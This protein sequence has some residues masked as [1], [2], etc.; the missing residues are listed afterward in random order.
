MVII[1]QNANWA[2][3]AFSSS[4]RQIDFEYGIMELK[5]W[6]INDFLGKPVALSSLE[7]RHQ[8]ESTDPALVWMWVF[9]GDSAGG[10]FGPSLLVSASW[11]GMLS[12]K[13]V[14]TDR[15]KM[16]VGGGGDEGEYLEHSSTKQVMR[17]RWE[18]RNQETAE[19]E[20]ETTWYVYKTSVSHIWAN[21][22]FGSRWSKQDFR[23]LCR[24]V[25]SR[26]YELIK[27]N[28]SI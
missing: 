8:T 16:L 19:N 14:T 3:E 27:R 17:C 21:T 1:H 7:V 9:L 4:M 10:H 6:R 13:I 15:W 2:T 5:M 11:A 28:E 20:N 18:E 25:Q 24:L 22:E 26:R 23:S 12:R